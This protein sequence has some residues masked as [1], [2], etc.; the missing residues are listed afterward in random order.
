MFPRTRNWPGSHAVKLMRCPEC[1]NRCPAKAGSCHHCGA[2]LARP[3]STSSPLATLAGLA[4]VGGLAFRFFIAA[5]GP[6]PGPAEK[7]ASRPA[8]SY[9]AVRPTGPTINGVTYDRSPLVE[10]LDLSQPA[11]PPSRSR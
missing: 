1:K 8:P 7:V 5:P 4:C 9:G 11:P 3:L 10:R 2:G 6:A